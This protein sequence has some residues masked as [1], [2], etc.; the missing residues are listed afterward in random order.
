MQDQD[1]GVQPLRDT[2]SHPT[3][4][5]LSFIPSDSSVRTLALLCD[6]HELPLW[7][8]WSQYFTCHLHRE[9]IHIVILLK[10]VFFHPEEVKTAVGP[11]HISDVQR[12]I[13]VPWVPGEMKLALIL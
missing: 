10:G 13:I 5:L 8:A 4:L 2:G 12:A 6:T 9:L 1:E 11:L 3:P 7:P